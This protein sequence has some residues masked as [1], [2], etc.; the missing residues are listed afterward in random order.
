MDPEASA[1]DAFQQEWENMLPY[2]FPPFSLIGR[3]L[4]KLNNHTST[5]MI[6]IAP[7][8]TT[9]PWYPLLLEMSMENP[10]ILP[11]RENLLLNPKGETH[12]NA[13]KLQLA[14][15]KVSSRDSKRREFRRRLLTSSATNVGNQHSIVTT[16][17]GRSSLAGSWNGV[18][19]H[20]DAI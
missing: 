15:W 1:I 13:G 2:A 16:A 3:V 8:W 12:P 5:D 14:A 20:F 18:I 4:R 9:Q 11:R 7:V 10:I 19:I 17:P 6:M